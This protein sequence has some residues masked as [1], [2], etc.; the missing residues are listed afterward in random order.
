MPPRVPKPY[1]V[2]AGANIVVIKIS[3]QNGRGVQQIMMERGTRHVD[4]YTYTH[5]HN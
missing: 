4:T 1:G 5:T 2:A 3:L